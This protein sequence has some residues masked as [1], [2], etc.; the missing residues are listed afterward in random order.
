MVL[1]FLI[2]LVL[3]FEWGILALILLALHI[4][5]IVPWWAPL[6]VVG[7]WVLHA[8]AI[9][10]FL[11]TLNRWGNEPPKPTKNV[12]PYT[13]KNSDYPGGQ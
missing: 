11:G 7:I 10:L 5:W 3:R 12:N 13:K 2:N 1:S 9:T 6:A 4:W 8:L